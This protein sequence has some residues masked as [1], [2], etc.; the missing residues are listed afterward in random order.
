MILVLK[1]SYWDK[2]YIISYEFGKSS[3]LLELGHVLLW[4][5]TK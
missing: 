3:K 2:I 1:I 4:L 5:K